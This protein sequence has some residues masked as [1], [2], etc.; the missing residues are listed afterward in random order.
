MGGAL[1]AT[2]LCIPICPTPPPCSVTTPTPPRVAQTSTSVDTISSTHIHTSPRPSVPSVGHQAVTNWSGWTSTPTSETPWQHPQLTVDW[3]TLV[4]WG[5]S[6]TALCPGLQRA[7]AHSYTALIFRATLDLLSFQRAPIYSLPHQKLPSLN[8]ACLIK[9][10]STAGHDSRR[11]TVHCVCTQITCCQCVRC[12]CDGGSLSACCHVISCMSL[13][14]LTN[15]IAASFSAH[16][17]PVQM[18]AHVFNDSCKGHSV[19]CAPTCSRRQGSKPSLKR[20]ESQITVNPN[21][22][23]S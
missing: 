12:E 3:A 6:W 2:S 13:T 19:Y 21:L 22:G 23:P 1:S 14:T 16:F 20:S 9:H 5:H 4:R 8:L 18:L 15:F 17:V 10:P 7:T 11:A